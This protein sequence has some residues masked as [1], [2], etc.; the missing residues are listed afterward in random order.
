MRKYLIKQSEIEAMTFDELVEHGKRV[1]RE[2][3]QELVNGMPWSFEVNGYPV[4]HEND[5]CY[6]VN[7]LFSSAHMTPDFVLGFEGRSVRLI[8]KSLFEEMYTEVPYLT[9]EEEP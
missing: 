9:D 5:K 8:K 7:S 3:G 6:I 2:N 4:T 1:Y